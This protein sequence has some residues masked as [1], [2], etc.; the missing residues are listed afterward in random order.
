MKKTMPAFEARRQFGKLLDDVAQKGDRIVVERNGREVAAV[1]PIWLYR[2]F[3]RERQE[4]FEE[5]RAVSERA[6]M[7]EDDAEALAAKAVRW[8]RGQ[9]NGS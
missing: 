5:M 4:F 8:A 7:S 9:L 2:Q 6:N 3:E 1:V